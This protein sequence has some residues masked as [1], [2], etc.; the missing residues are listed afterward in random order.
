LD[1]LKLSFVFISPLEVGQQ[2][3]PSSTAQTLLFWNQWSIESC[4]LVQTS[5][6]YAL[7]CNADPPSD[8]NLGTFDKVES[9]MIYLDQN[10]S[11]Q[12]FINQ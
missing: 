3:H 8:Q 11:G 10:C 9:K 1:K 12:T 6:V 2:Y 4:C 7:S 5:I